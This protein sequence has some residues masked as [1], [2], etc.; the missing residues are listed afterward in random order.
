MWFA[1]I[2]DCTL[3]PTISHFLMMTKYIS[4]L[5]QMKWIAWKAP[6]EIM[7]IYQVQS[8]MTKRYSKNK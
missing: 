2:E 3:G 8:Y 6:P 5:K 1:K 7:L 4:Y